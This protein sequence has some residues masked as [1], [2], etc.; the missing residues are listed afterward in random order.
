MGIVRNCDH[1]LN[2]FYR[3]SWFHQRLYPIR[4]YVNACLHCGAH[5][6]GS[7][8]CTKPRDC[9]QKKICSKLHAW[10]TPHT[11][12]T[13]A[14]RIL[15]QQIAQRRNVDARTA[16]FYFIF[17]EAASS[18]GFFGGQVSFFF[19]PVSRIININKLFPEVFISPHIST[20]Q[21]FIF[22]FSLD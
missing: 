11:P 21:H 9:R 16:V 17:A 5:G 6:G 13:H 20:M 14:W 3:S 19:F 15:P 8:S 4:Q 7:F 18:H 22:Y 2:R 1:W 10:H 12:H